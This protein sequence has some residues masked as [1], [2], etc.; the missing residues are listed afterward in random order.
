[1]TVELHQPFAWP[2]EPEDLSAWNSPQLEKRH[3][4]MEDQKQRQEKAQKTGTFPLRE[5]VGAPHGRISLKK[6]AQRLLKEGKWTNDRKLDPKFIEG[7]GNK[8]VKEGKT[9]DS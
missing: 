1:M 9:E 2:E 5:E 3:Q 8:A 4:E 7:K 6:E